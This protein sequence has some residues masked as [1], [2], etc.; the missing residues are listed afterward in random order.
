[1]LDLGAAIRD[2]KE[3]F[4][5]KRVVLGGWSGGG[6][7]SLFYQRQAREPSI[8]DTPA[9]D[10]LDLTSVELPAADAMLLLAAHPSRHRV[11][12]DSID[13]SIAGRGA[14]RRSAIRR[15][16]CTRATTRTSRRTRTS[17]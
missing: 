13:P 7:L 2:A 4:G 10:P 6:A 15:S 1:M 11:L 16:T 17:S 9:G 3:R 8:T 12:T 14:T 5:Y